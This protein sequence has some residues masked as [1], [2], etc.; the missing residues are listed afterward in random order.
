MQFLQSA[1]STKEREEKQPSN[2][3]AWLWPMDIFYNKKH[4]LLQMP[5][6]WNWFMCTQIGNNC[7]T[8]FSHLLPLTDR[9]VLCS[10]KRDS[11]MWSLGSL[12]CSCSRW[13]FNRGV[14]PAPL[15]QV[16]IF[17]LNYRASGPP[18]IFLSFVG[19]LVHLRE[20][21]AL[22]AGGSLMQRHWELSW[23]SSALALQRR[24]LFIK[25][26]T[27]SPSPIP[28]FP[29]SS[30]LFSWVHLPYSVLM[31]ETPPAPPS[32]HLP[33]KDKHEAFVLQ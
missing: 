10:L 12:F 5:V 18:W 6:R 3:R 8:V 27:Y 13:I 14:Q 32:N 4:Y 22:S 25:A 33:P 9:H 21:D 7:Y 30:R 15:P 28:L 20:E 23:R 1:L 29:R 2:A 17:M 11:L 31:T 19:A 24:A 26:R 16:N